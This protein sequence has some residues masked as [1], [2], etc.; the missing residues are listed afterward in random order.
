MPHKLFAL[1]LGF[2]AL[3]FAAQQSS[4]QQAGCAQ[5][6]QILAELASRYGETRRSVGLSAS[7]AVVELFASDASGSWTIT[8]TLASGLTCIV[9]AGLAYEAVAEAPGNGA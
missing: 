5:R 1:S 2:A 6:A 8:V 7:N 9:A 4:A 3:I